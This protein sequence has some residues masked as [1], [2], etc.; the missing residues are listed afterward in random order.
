MERVI[1]SQDVPNE[2]EG[3]QDLLNQLSALMFERNDWA[4]GMGV[5]CP[6]EVWQAELKA[7]DEGI[8]ALRERIEPLL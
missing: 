5:W 1:T 4:S 3:L 2:R 7:F 6:D 8:A